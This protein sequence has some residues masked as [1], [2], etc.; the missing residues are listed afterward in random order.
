MIATSYMVFAAEVH[1]NSERLCPPSCPSLP[2]L[3]DIDPTPDGLQRVRH[4]QPLVVVAMDTQANAGVRGLDIPHDFVHLFFEQ[5]IQRIRS[6]GCERGRPS[7]VQGKI[8]ARWTG[9]YLT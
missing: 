5:F 6:V 9:S 1:G 2:H 8:R 3:H 7:A 4:R